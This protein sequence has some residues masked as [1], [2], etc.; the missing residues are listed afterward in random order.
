MVKTGL[1]VGS[2]IPPTLGHLDVIQR[3]ARLCE[4]LYVGIGIDPKKSQALFSPDERLEML[5]EITREISN[6]KIVL[7]PGLV[8][9]FI[10]ENQVDVLLRG[11]RSS[12][13]LDREREL[14]VTNRQICGVET[15]FL[16]SDPKYSHLSSSIIREIASFGHRLHG[17]VPE[18]IEESVFQKMS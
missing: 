12:A 13:D 8:A 11:L 3:G 18:Q 6:A 2:F 16:L 10:R 4:L 17:F 14:A 15:F 7:V 5:R 1:F 9:D